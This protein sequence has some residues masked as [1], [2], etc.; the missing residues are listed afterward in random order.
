MTKNQMGL[1]FGFFLAIVHVIWLVLVA[2]IPVGMQAFVDWVFALHGMSI[3]LLITSVT[4][5]GA[6]SLVLLTFVIGYVSG[7]IF[8]WL[9]KRIKR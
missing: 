5:N 6:I 3:A 7:F 8:G 9:V 4:W 2:L 1:V